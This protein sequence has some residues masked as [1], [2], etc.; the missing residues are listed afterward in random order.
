MLETIRKHRKKFFGV[1]MLGLISMLMLG[2]GID[3]FF[4]TKVETYA[5]KINGEEIPIDEFY[6]KRE[7]INSRYRNQLGD[8]YE[9]FKDSLNLNQT[10]VDQI[11][12]EKIAQSF[13]DKIKLKASKSA[14]MEKIAEDVKRYMG[15][16]LT[17]NSYSQFLQLIGL[18]GS[19]LE[20]QTQQQLIQAQ[21]LGVIG[22]LNMPTSVEAEKVFNKNNIK[23]KLE[24]LSFTPLEE[25]KKNISL[26][27]EELKKFYEENKNNFENPE[28]VEISLVKFNSR[29]FFDKVDISEE[30]L[31]TAYDENSYK[32]RT[33]PK[34]RLAKLSL[35]KSK[36]KEEDLGILKELTGEKEEESA[37]KFNPNSLIKNKLRDI[38]KEAQELAFED[39]VSKYSEDEDS[40]KNSGD[41]GLLEIRNLN[42]KISQA[43]NN[44]KVGDISDIVEEDNFFSIFYVKEK[45][46]SKEKDF[47]QVKPILKSELQMEDA[48]LYAR[49]A[50]EEFIQQ[51][52]SSDKTFGEFAKEQNL[53]AIKSSKPLKKYQGE[54]NIPNEITNKALELSDGAS[55]V[56]EIG[57]DSYAVYV[58]KLIPAF[59]PNFEEVKDKVETQLLQKK[60]KELAKERAE[61]ILAKIQ[62]NPSDISKI[63][64]EAKNQ[65]AEYREIEEQTKN[66]PPQDIWSNSTVYQKAFLLSTGEVINEVIDFK[67]AF[68]IVIAKNSIQDE[69]KKFEDEKKSIIEA[70]KNTSSAKNYYV[71]IEE[72]KKNSEIEINPKI[73]DSK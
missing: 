66:T 52:S 67:G 14:V 22:E 26:N 57:N 20:A 24:V 5:A 65:K 34:I 17:K 40:K 27:D 48:P 36:D 39:L 18:S 6:K 61:A 19:S 73:L 1:V 11:I 53:E 69:D 71:L 10:A 13:S 43:T 31:K 44:L 12:N 64:E 54:N 56:F 35:K 42:P 23:V 51:W 46:E 28:T 30:D 15:T 41:L 62:S 60:S 63:I 16:E 68:N 8:K 9:M 2:F 45:E 4:R 29:D 33:E 37:N 32:Y 25:D 49:N 70:Q 72:L 58:E 50:A 38:S 55:E 7:I 59:I 3:S 21:L 47:E